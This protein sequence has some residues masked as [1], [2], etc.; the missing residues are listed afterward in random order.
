MVLEQL[1]AGVM[2]PA[3]TFSDA[4]VEEKEMSTVEDAAASALVAYLSSRSDS[5]G[6]DLHV[7]PRVIPALKDAISKA[8]LRLVPFC[9]CYPS[10]F[11][12]TYSAERKTLRLHLRGTE[13]ERPGTTGNAEAD[14]EDRLVAKLSAYHTNRPTEATD[15]APLTWL[16]RSAAGAVESLVV[17]ANS[18]RMHFHLR[19]AQHGYSDRLSAW[20]ACAAAHIEAFVRARPS[21]LVWHAGETCE[22]HPAGCWCRAGVSLSVQTVLR[23]AKEKAAAAAAAAAPATAAHTAPAAGIDLAAH[24]DTVAPAAP[25][26][27]SFG[28]ALAASAILPG[29]ATSGDAAPGA[30]GTC[31][32]RQT[33]AAQWER[34]EEFLPAPELSAALDV[35]GDLLVLRAA[36]RTASVFAAEL[37]AAAASVSLPTHALRS[38]GPGLWQLLP[39]AQGGAGPGGDP[40]T[41]LNRDTGGCECMGGAG[42]GDVVNGG[43]ADAGVG[44]GRPQS[45]RDRLLWL[46]PSLVGVRA[47]ATVLHVS[48]S[49]AGMFAWLRSAAGAAAVR[50]SVLENGGQRRWTLRWESCHPSPDS[51]SLPFHPLG[52]A[53]AVSIALAEVLGTDGFVS[54]EGGE[55]GCEGGESAGSEEGGPQDIAWA[56][57]RSSAPVERTAPERAA[58]P[59]TGERR[60]GGR[61]ATLVLL[62]TKAAVVLMRDLISE[63]RDRRGDDGRDVTS[64]SAAAL[65]VP[66]WCLAWERRCFAFSSALDP[67]V[68]CVAVRLAV[69]AHGARADLGPGHADTAER[70]PDPKPSHSPPSP[71]ALRVYDPCVGSGTMLAAAASMGCTRLVGSDLRPDFVSQAADNLRQA[72]LLPPTA[73]LFA[74]DAKTPLPPMSS[75]VDVVVSNPPW[76]KNCGAASDGVAIVRSVTAQLAGATFCWSAQ[77]HHLPRACPPPDLPPHRAAVRHPPPRARPHVATAPSGCHLIL[78]TGLV[79]ARARSCERSRRARAA[80]DGR[81]ARADARSVRER[82][83]CGRTDSRAN[84]SASEPVGG[85]RARR[86]GRPHL[87]LFQK[88]RGPNTSIGRFHRLAGNPTV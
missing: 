68:A 34:R 8:P 77:R 56:S 71:H 52:M 58:G 40:G 28:V 54:P 53:P 11:A 22:L 42:G 27:V 73:E 78:P 80:R 33:C 4:P 20:W 26:A 50:R 51:R 21:S 70:P 7:A 57:A 32:G 39:A 14:L 18:P 25:V 46:L 30:A 6:M 3:P 79:R 61:C 88:G 2:L 17:A 19:P 87:F 23:L 72:G 16:M 5:K 1:A 29:E 13:L 49:T 31:P 67:L 37:F 84:A 10:Q 38:L 62:Q 15:P 24:G 47:C 41:G 66:R 74:H 83:P 86:P 48:A 76:G 60:V 82:R 9:Q 45:A 64:P 81:R 44:V 12:L 35:G 65:R 36:N 85:V 75:P 63:A 43:A 59:P 55:A 69:L